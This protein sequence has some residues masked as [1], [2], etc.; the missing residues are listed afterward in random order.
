[1]SAT[2]VLAGCDL[3]DPSIQYEDY[4]LLGKPAPR[5]TVDGADFPPVNDVVLLEFWGLWCADCIVDAPH[6]ARVRQ[7]F[8]SEPRVTLAAIHGGEYGR[9]GSISGYFA[10]TGDPFD[11]LD[12]PEFELA[13]LYE[14]DWFPSY[15]VIDR[16]GT[17]VHMQTTLSRRDGERR[18][19]EAIRTQLS[20]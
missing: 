20:K 10:E 8:A 13:G 17:I 14:M 18:L 19:V 12:D 11:T 9:W 7:E 1:L 6:T 3:V 5:F 15:L 2:I 16:N 4:S